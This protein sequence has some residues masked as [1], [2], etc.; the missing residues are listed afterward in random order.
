MFESGDTQ[1]SQQSRPCIAG[2]A[3]AQATSDAERGP[4]SGRRSIGDRA[5]GVMRVMRELLLLED[6]YQGFQEEI[7]DWP[8][9]DPTLAAGRDPFRKTP[10]GESPRPSEGV[11]GAIERPAG[12]ERGTCR[13]SVAWCTGSAAAMST[14]TGGRCAQGPPRPWRPRRAGAPWP[15]LQLCVCPVTPSQTPA[16]DSRCTPGA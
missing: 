3:C 16:P 13:A 4:Q 11:L 10:Q 8:P 9:Q 6:E 15:K 14:A 1:A 12:G 5:L 2:R 7:S